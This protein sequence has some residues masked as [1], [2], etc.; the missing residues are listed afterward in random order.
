MTVQ[1]NKEKNVI[2]ELTFEFALAAMKFAEMVQEKRK[3]V[4]ADQFLRAGLSLASN[5][6]EAQN[7]ES[8]ADFVHKMKI[9]AKEADEA[10]LYLML[11]KQAENYPFEDHLLDKIKVIIKV[12]SKIIGTSKRSM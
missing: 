8:K 10:E 7:A 6:K 2:L 4:M 11:C 5:V 9:A 3:Y 12:L 1:D